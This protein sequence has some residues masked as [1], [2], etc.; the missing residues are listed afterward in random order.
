[1]M[2]SFSL[3]YAYVAILFC[4]TIYFNVVIV[5]PLQIILKTEID[6]ILKVPALVVNVIIWKIENRKKHIDRYHKECIYIDNLFPPYHTIDN[7]CNKRHT[8]IIHKCQIT[9]LSKK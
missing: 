7:P 5:A 6:A 8:T 9:F 4:F 2:L 1:M 3:P